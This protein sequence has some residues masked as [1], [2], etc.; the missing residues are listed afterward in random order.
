MT[1]TTTLYSWRDLNEAHDVVRP[2]RRCAYGGFQIKTIIIG[3]TIEDA[4]VVF[5]GGLWGEHSIHLSVSSP[6]R[7][8]GHFEGYA[9]KNGVLSPKVGDLVA[10]FGAAGR[11]PRTAKV[12]KATRRR[13]QI[14]WRYRHGGMS[15]P[16]WV[17]ISE[18]IFR[19][20]P[21]KP[22]LTKPTIAELL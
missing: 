21:V 17:P 13:V 8:L 11:L 19:T 7:I 18:V 1:N 14:E 2:M 3:K 22:V 15:A 10:F 20:F 16:R 9:A 6:E 12:L 5:Q 4:E